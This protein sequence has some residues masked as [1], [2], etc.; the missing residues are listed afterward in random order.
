MNPT[1]WFVEE[2]PGILCSNEESACLCHDFTDGTV[3]RGGYWQDVAAPD[4][5]RWK[6][7]RPDRV[8]EI[9]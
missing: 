1:R 9:E 6:Q 2:W 5:E 3:F 7:A 8:L 4:F